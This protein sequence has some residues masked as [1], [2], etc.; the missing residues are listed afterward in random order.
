MGGWGEWNLVASLKS[1]ATCGHT[2]QRPAVRSMV[3]ENAGTTTLWV[4]GL[5]LDT[6]LLAAGLPDLTWGHPSSHKA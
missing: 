6:G 4:V 2:T 1:Q 3:S 5:D